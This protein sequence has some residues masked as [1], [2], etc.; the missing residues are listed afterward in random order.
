MTSSSSSLSSSLIK[1]DEV[2]TLKTKMALF[3]IALNENDNN[4]KNALF[5]DICREINFNSLLK[6]RDFA[7]FREHFEIFYTVLTNHISYKM[8]AAAAA[9]T[10]TTAPRASIPMEIVQACL[11]SCSFSRHL[12]LEYYNNHRHCPR[13]HQSK[14]NLNGDGGGSNDQSRKR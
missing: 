2:D 9:T 4:E 8:E 1:L 7:D 13:C 6:F 10:T 3:A 11:L 12:E 5:M 14:Y